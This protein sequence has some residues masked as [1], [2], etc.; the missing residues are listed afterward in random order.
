MLQGCAYQAK[1]FYF[2]SEIKQ[3]CLKRPRARV[4]KQKK[5]LGNV[6]LATM[7]KN[8][9]DKKKETGPY[10]DLCVFFKRR[11]WNSK[12]HFK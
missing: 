4:G 6:N 2:I 1:D 12:I 5:Y 7:C 8:R 10:S 3:S 9:R 11:T